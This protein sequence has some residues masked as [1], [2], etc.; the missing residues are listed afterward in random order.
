VT[1]YLPLRG[2]AVNTVNLVYCDFSDEAAMHSAKVNGMGQY[3]YTDPG[4][5]ESYDDERKERKRLH[6][7][8]WGNADE[9]T[10]WTADAGHAL[11]DFEV[12]DD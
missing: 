9:I 7:L 2:H 4:E 1:L 5:K 3:S 10:E 12:G 8:E 6:G 11:I